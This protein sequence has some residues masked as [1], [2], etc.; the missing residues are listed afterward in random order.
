MWHLAVSL[1]SPSDEESSPSVDFG[2]SNDSAALHMAVGFAHRGVHSIGLFGPT[3]PA[4]VGPYGGDAHVLRAPLPDGR[5]VNYRDRD[6]GDSI[7]RGIDVDAVF[8]RIESVRGTA[9]KV[10]DP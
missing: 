10:A 4:K 8:E 6:I 7:M 1:S 9:S 3:D 5:A 2:N